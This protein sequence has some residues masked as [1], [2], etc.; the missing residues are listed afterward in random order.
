MPCGKRARSEAGPDL[1]QTKVRRSSFSD[2]AA[3]RWSHPFAM[4]KMNELNQPRSPRYA[5]G[6]R[7]ASPL[8]L[9]E[10]MAKTLEA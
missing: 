10:T 1:G 7:V 2:L 9:L 3:T 8:A 4:V 5:A 6:L